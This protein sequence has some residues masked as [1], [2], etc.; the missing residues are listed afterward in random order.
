VTVA[1]ANR[2]RILDRYP[3]A[4][5]LTRYG[6]G[7]VVAAPAGEL[8]FVLAYA[9]GHLGT[10][11]ASAAGFL[12]AVV[13]SYLLNRRW[14]WSDRR[15]L[16]RRSEL[17]RYLGVALAGFVAAAVGTYWAKDGARDL[18]SSQG[19]RVVLVAAAYLAVSAVFF[20][21][22]FICFELLVFTPGRADRPDH[23]AASTARVK[24]QA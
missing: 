18:T 10:T 19:W 22:K 1:T 13:P 6:A 12:A 2:W 8:A 23:Q 3:W 20:F 4:R 14:A 21:A 16:D 17:V 24:P 7:S 5:R 11:L 9:W 15:G